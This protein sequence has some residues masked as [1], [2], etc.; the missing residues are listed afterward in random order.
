MCINLVQCRTEFWE[1][2]FDFFLGS[3]K[4]KTNQIAQRMIKI[5]NQNGL[6][7]QGTATYSLLFREL[8]LHI[9]ISGSY[10]KA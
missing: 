9:S 2:H 5:K 6:P 7:R 8:E 4:G 3:A 1:D 10:P